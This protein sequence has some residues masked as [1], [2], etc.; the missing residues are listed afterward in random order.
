MPTAVEALVDLRRRLVDAEV[1]LNMGSKASSSH[2]AARLKAKAE[3]VA[4]AR[5]HLQDV[6]AL[7]EHVPV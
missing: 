5:D 1:E 2:E 4:L 3:G 7:A 6:L